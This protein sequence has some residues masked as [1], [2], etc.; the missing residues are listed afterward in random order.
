MKYLFSEGLVLIPLYVC[1]CVCLCVYVCVC[2]CVCLCVCVCVCVCVKTDA[3]G[4]FC[5]GE[6][7]TAEPILEILAKFCFVLLVW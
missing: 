5:T 4:R 7:K 1:V 2:V 6:L 3:K